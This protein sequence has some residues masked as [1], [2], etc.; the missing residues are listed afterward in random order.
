[1]NK[2]EIHFCEV[3]TAISVMREVASW[4][5]EQGYR[6]WHDE[7]LTV[8]ELI[9]PDAHPENFCI[10]TIDG[11]QAW[12]SLYPVGHRSGRKGS[13]KDLSVRWL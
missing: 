13:Q 5:R 3:E 10:G 11:E 12:Y 1:M 7:W 9:T 6:V 8:E 2:L 4:D